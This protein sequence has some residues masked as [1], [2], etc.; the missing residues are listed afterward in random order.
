MQLTQQSAPEN[1][2]FS[3]MLGQLKDKLHNTLK[4][5][6]SFQ[7]KNAEHVFNTGTPLPLTRIACFQ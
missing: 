4:N 5:L 2:G 7:I 6:E 1:V 3:L